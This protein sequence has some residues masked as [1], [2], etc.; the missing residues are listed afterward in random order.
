MKRPIE[1]M[2]KVPAQRA[3]VEP[4]CESCHREP[5]TQQVTMPSMPDYGLPA[6]T[7]RLGDE[8][9]A[10]ARGLVAATAGITR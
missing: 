5:A 4:T 7:F 8:C 2:S 6:E 10:F 1:Y 3:N 9:A